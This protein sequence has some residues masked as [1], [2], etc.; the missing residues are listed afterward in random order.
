MR[1]E[2]LDPAL[3]F[4]DAATP[5]PKA[6]PSLA[7]QIKAGKKL[8]QSAPAAASPGGDAAAGLEGAVE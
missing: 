4:G 2:G 7:E 1:V 8:K 6:V 3:L 5:A